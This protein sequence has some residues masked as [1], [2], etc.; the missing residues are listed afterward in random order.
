MKTLVILASGNSTRF[1][2]T[3][4]V[5]AD[6][7]GISNLENTIRYAK[8]IYDRVLLTLNQEVFH[9]YSGKGNINCEVSIVPGGHGDA[10][11]FLEVVKNM[12]YDEEVSLCWGDAIFRSDVPFKVCSTSQYNIGVV[13]ALDKN[14]YA[15]FE[16]EDFKILDSHFRKDNPIDIGWH[17]QSLFRINVPY[18]LKYLTLYKECVNIATDE[19]KIINFVSWLAKTQNEYAHIIPI[20][21]GLVRSFNT[22]EEL[23]EAILC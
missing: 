4:K 22:I 7:G 5:F 17:D 14:P 1:G 11:S 13:S 12:S 10:Y 19:M 21:T 6:V 3:P 2:K 8:G 9:V 16:E 20:E 15:W 18:C 23:K